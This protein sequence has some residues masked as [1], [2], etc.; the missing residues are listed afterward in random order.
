LADKTRLDAAVDRLERVVAR[1]EALA[2]GRAR[3]AEAL[4]AARADYVALEGLTQTARSRLDAAI[5]RL[6]SVLGR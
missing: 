5:G 3:T 2:A 4:K 6:E 1:L